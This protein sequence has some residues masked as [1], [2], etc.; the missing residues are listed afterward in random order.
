MK[1]RHQINTS[2]S[3]EFI[4]K[5]KKTRENGSGFSTAE[6]VLFSQYHLLYCLGCCSSE[7]I[8]LLMLFF[9]SVSHCYCCEGTSL[10]SGT[11]VQFCPM[12]GTP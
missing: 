2:P 4:N 10:L 8:L 6:T 3:P 12:I 9:W 1:R 5:Y 7:E 11:I